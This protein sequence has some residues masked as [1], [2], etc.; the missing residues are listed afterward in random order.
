MFKILDR[1]IERYIDT[2]ETICEISIYFDKEIVHTY[3]YIYI[4]T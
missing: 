3:I 4:Y 1:K 2:S